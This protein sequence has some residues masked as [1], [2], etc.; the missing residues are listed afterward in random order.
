M[1]VRL[2]F[3]ADV[4][5]FIYHN[6]NN[7]TCLCPLER[8]VTTG[9]H[10]RRIVTMTRRLDDQ[11]LQTRRNAPFQCLS[12][13]AYVKD[14]FP[15][16]QHVNVTVRLFC[17]L[18]YVGRRGEGVF[19]IKGLPA[20]SS[21]RKWCSPLNRRFKGTVTRTGTRVS[22][23]QAAGH[24]CHCLPA[25]SGKTLAIWPHAVRYLLRSSATYLKAARFTVYIL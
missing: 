14:N 3:T 15:V 11:Q 1:Q 4:H 6:E 2:L 8:D 10:I 19:C 5:T 23:L 18:C 25:T 24:L 21:G 7:I 12:W 22:R 20:Y 13:A 16:K 9:G 17:S